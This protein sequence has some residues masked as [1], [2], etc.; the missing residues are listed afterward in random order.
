MLLKF[1]S[2]YTVCNGKFY[3]EEKEVNLEQQKWN[4]EA[5]VEIKFQVNFQCRKNST[6]AQIRCGIVRNEWGREY[7][8]IPSVKNSEKRHWK[9][10]EFSHLELA[11]WKIKG[12]KT[13]TVRLWLDK[14][15]K[16]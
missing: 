16:L 3:L 9:C 15:A 5:T 12:E 14:R 1:I 13:H 11:K 10:E 6:K 8:Q 7:Y 4:D 2:F